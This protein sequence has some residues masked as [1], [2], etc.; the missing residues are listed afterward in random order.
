MNE[1]THKQDT[2]LKIFSTTYMTQLAQ[3]QKKVQDSYFERLFKNKV[4]QNLCEL[5]KWCQA[6]HC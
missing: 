5:F 4:T 2:L 3:Q 6:M 1:T